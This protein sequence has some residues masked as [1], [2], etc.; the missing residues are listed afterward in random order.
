[1][2]PLN[3]DY[4][5]DISKR[6]F[7]LGGSVAALGLLTTACP[8][9]GVTKDNA[10]RYS[11]IAINYLKDILPIA[12]QLGGTQVAGF[13]NQAIP[14]LEKLREALEKNE[15]PTAGNLFDNVTSILGQTA[16]ALL[17][18]PESP[19]RNTIIGILTLVNVTMR[20]VSLF[21][22]SNAPAAAVPRN[23]RSAA[24]PSPLLRA[25]EA[26]SDGGEI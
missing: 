5:V 6:N 26:S 1:M 10:V 8:F 24:A 21:I 12:S 16:T 11:S 2:I 4:D 14:A 22:D 19:R 15:F 7:M 23:V 3:D 17:Q 20:T 25:F 18:L 13:V 9:D